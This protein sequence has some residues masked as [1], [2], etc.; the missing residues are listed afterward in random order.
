MKSLVRQNYV[1]S[2]RRPV[3]GLPLTSLG[4]L[5]LVMICTTL[6]SPSSAAGPSAESQLSSERVEQ[7]VREYLMREP[8]LVYDALEELQRREQTEKVERIRLAALE[9]EDEL[10]NN[11]SS[12]IGGNADGDVTLV[13]FFD[14]RCGYCRHVV[15]T[16]ETLISEDDGIKVVFKELP[17]L[18]E[19]SERATRAAL[20]SREQGAYERF[21]FALMRAE[22]FSKAGILSL[23]EDNGLDADRLLEDMN[24]PDVSRT[25]EENHELAGALGV[26]GTP[27]F[28]IGGKVIPGAAELEQLRA[29]VEEARAG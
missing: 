29:L 28:I 25:I 24:G 9:H 15:S 4:F 22:D 5:G 19:E 27:M 17:I 8:Q 20:A 10:Y 11:P 1:A 3:N 14:Y 18:G 6:N 21:H 16:L 2:L 23:A 12:P 26:A 7:I 13:E